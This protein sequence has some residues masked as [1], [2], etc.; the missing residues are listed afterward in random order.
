VDADVPHLLAFVEWVGVVLF[1]D[2]DAAHGLCS[3]C[4]GRRR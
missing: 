1:A 3:G 2:R 4:G